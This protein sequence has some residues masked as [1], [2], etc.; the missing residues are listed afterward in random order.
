MPTDVEKLAAYGSVRPQELGRTLKWTRAVRAARARENINLFVEHVMKDAKTQAPI[1]QADMHKAWHQLADQ[2]RRLVL[3]SAVHSGKTT[4][5]SVARSLWLLGRDPTMRIA[6]VSNTHKQASDI[7]QVIARY[8]EQSDELHEVF[9]HLRKSP[10]KSDLWNTHAL[11]IDRPNIAKEPSVQAFGYRG[12]IT[13]ARLDLIIIDDLLDYENCRTEAQRD[14]LRNW[15]LSHL[16]GRDPGDGSMR[17]LCIGT[18]YNPQDLMHEFAR[19][20]A[21]ASYRYPAID[22]K[23]NLRWPWTPQMIQE[24]QHDMGP[25]EF[26]RQV[27]CVARDN[28]NSRIKEEWVRKAVDRGAN[29]RMA[30]ALSQVPPG[31]R[32]YTGVDLAVQKHSAADLTAFSTIVVH[33]NGDREL[34]DLSSGRFAG[35]EIISKLIDIYRRYQSIIYVESN[36]AQEFLNQFIRS[37]TTLP[38]RSFVTGKNKVDPAFGVESLAAEMDA[39]RWIIPSQGGLTTEVNALLSDL[40]HYDPREHT[41]DRLMSLWIAKEA[42]RLGEIPQPRVEIGTFSITR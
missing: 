36:G 3:W 28:A 38:V 27:L 8:V 24:A 5:M 33:P 14:E 7:I 13:G 21:W 1:F 20:P 22:D 18:A 16:S 17:I 6:I 4:Q 41:G 29:K 23:G 25:I 40:L 26:P 9:P 31:Y 37:S 10:R 35:P 30:Y 12:N 11:T 15:Y 39:G 19:N 32:T 2:H 42:A 34:L